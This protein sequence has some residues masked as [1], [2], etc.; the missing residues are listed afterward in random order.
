MDTA[1]LPLPSRATFSFVRPSLFDPKTSS[2]TCSKLLPPHRQRNFLSHLFS[3]CHAPIF[4]SPRLFAISQAIGTLP[5]VSATESVLLT[6]LCNAS[7][8]ETTAPCLWQ[9]L[10]NHHVSTHKQHCTFRLN[11]SRLPPDPRC[12]P[13][14]HARRSCSN[15]I[16]PAFFRPFWLPSYTSLRCIIRVLTRTGSFFTTS[17]PPGP[18]KQISLGAQ[19]PCSITPTTCG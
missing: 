3:A 8:L 7:F 11:S 10:V 5:P 15:S 14:L 4:V 9:L 1:P 18:A 16:H 12:L 13:T 2:P 17:C 6:L 19:W